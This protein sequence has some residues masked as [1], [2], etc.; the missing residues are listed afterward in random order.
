MDEKGFRQFLKKLGKKEHVVEG[1]ISQVQAFETYLAGERQVGVEAAGEQN[2]RDYVAAH[3]H[4]FL[5]DRQYK[6]PPARSLTRTS[7]ISE[8]S[9]STGAATGLIL[10]L[11]P[12]A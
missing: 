3:H 5:N 7:C 10:R 9:K 2:I 11:L 6:S 4:G 12:G 1:L 8:G